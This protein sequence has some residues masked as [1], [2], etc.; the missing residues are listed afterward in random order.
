MWKKEE[1]SQAD[2]RP[3]QHEAMSPRNESTGASA[4]S[5]GPA[6]IGRS[7]TIRGEV[8]GDEDLLI[9]GRVDGSVDLKQHAVTVGPDGKVKAGISGRVVTVEGTVEGDLR[10]DEQV[11]LRSTAR[12]QG[13]ITAPRVI[14][15]DGANFRGGVEMGEPARGDRQR[16]ASRV[17]ESKPGTSTSATTGGVTGGAAGAGDANKDAAKD[18]PKGQGRDATE[19]TSGAKA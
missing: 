1:G 12:V 7:I 19:R 8:T 4:R 16:G 17:E 6:T 10:A 2:P 18:S 13:D 11:I 5:R 3:V 15:E 14:L 9:E